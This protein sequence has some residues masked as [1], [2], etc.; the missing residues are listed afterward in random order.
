MVGINANQC[1][2]R[3]TNKAPYQK[4]VDRYLNEMLSNKCFKQSTCLFCIRLLRI[5]PCGEWLISTE[6]LILRQFN[7]VLRAF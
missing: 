2:Q 5:H 6:G 4:A 1:F 7:E 3:G